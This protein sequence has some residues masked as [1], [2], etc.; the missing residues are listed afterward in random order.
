MQPITVTDLTQYRMPSSLRF[1]PDKRYGV[2][3]LTRAELTGN[4][5][6]STLWT[7]R[8]EDGTIRPLTNGGSERSFTFSGPHSVLFPAL[9]EERDKKAVQGGALLTVFYEIDLEGGEAVKRFRLPLSGA[10]AQ[11]IDGRWYAVTAS[12]DNARP[13][14]SALEGAALAEAKQ[15]WEEEKDYQVVDEVPFW[16]NGRGYINKKRSRLYLYDSETGTLTPLTEPLFDTGVVQVDGGHRRIVYFGNTFDGVQGLG[17]GLFV[18]DIDTGATRCLIDQEGYTI[19]NLALD[20]AGDRVIFAGSPLQDSGSPLIHGAPR[21]GNSVYA[22][23][24][25]D[26]TV[27]PLIEPCP[28][29]IGV[30]TSCDVRY[31]GGQT[32]SVSDGTVYLITTYETSSGISAIEEGHLRHI[33]PPALNVDFFQLVDGA[34][35]AACQWD[36]LPLELCRIDMATGEHTQLSRFHRDFLADKYVAQPQPLSAHSPDGTRVDGFV[37]LPMDFDPRKRY[38][39]ILQIHGGPRNSF[40]TGHMHEMQVMVGEGCFVFFCNPRGSAGRGNDFADIRGKYGDIDFADIMAFTD[41]VLAAYPQLDGER[42]GVAGGSYGGFMTNWVIG[43]THRFKAAASQRSIANWVTN[44]GVSD[45]GPRYCTR[46]LGGATPWNG[47]ERMWEMSPLRYAMDVET[48][49]LFI[50]SDEDYRCCLPEGIQMFT[51]LKLKGVPARMC[52]FHKENHEL[53]RSGK[54]KHRLRRLREINS[55]L[56]RYIKP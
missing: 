7:L 14:F 34:A 39:G 37:L 13:D 55:W 15:S 36:A 38:P 32:L 43:H 48:P 5:Y 27:T 1:S 4:R 9:R 47:I 45:V 53:S 41:A 18:Y 17:K 26:G 49:T 3:C 29:D 28:E 25:H 52:I 46:E 2:F 51:A 6:V 19:R 30:A 50:H 40:C 35:Y 54:P 22:V 42:L 23:S 10:S 21:P 24:L 11:A 44:Y 8:R 31:G 20:T 12:F 56:F 33:T 16:F